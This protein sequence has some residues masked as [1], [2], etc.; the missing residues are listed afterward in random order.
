ME[1]SGEASV[2]TTTAMDPWL[3]WVISKILGDGKQWYV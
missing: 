2:L 1:P 3:T